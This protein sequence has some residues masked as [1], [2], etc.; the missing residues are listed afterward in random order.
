M[1]NLKYILLIVSTFL[2]SCEDFLEKKPLDSP[3]T[4]SFLNN[5]QEM[6]ASLNS[7]YRSIHWDRGLTPIQQF[8]D[9]WS[10]IG[11]FRDPGIA[12]GDFDTNNADVQKIWTNAYITIQRANTLINGMKVG[13]ENVTPDQYERI[14][15]E[16]RVIRAWAYHFLAFMFGN[17]PL[18][19]EPLLP[20]KY[21]M[22]ATSKDKVI[23][24][25]IKELDESSKKLAWKPTTRGHV[26]KGVALGLLSR[27]ALY[28]KN[29]ELASTAAFEV[30]NSKEF[31]LNPRFQ[32][33]FTR[34]GQSVNKN[35]EIM[36]EFYRSDNSYR[37]VRNYVPLGQ[38][39]RNLGGQSGKFPTQRLVDMFE[40]VDGKRIDESPLYDPENPSKNR[41][42]RLR[43]TVAMHGDTITHYGA[44]NLPRTCIFNI[45]DN[46]TQFYNYTTNKWYTAT[47]N[48]FS[49]PYGPVSSGVG[50]LTAKYTY[51][52]EQINEARVSWIYL[53]YA[54]ILL[55]YAEA[56]IELNRL[57]EQT[58]QVINQVRL[59]SSMPAVDPLIQHSQLEMKQLIRR[60]RTVE[61][62]M[63]GFRW[64]DIRRWE[65][66]EH[67]FPGLIVGASKNKNAVAIPNFKTNEITDL[68]NIPDYSQ[69]INNRITRDTRYYD[70]KHYLL[71]IPQR[72]IDLNPNLNQNTGW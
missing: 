7:L 64:F 47:N 18:V 3:T 12:T 37:S 22:D 26:G 56:N 60:E 55:T 32:D 33:L 39:S 15:A 41:D 54:E 49:N 14:E 13:K 68:N 63:E 28:N 70:K 69:S 25:I 44:N 6:E 31:S 45:Y 52:D 16:A 71:P 57:N 40:C 9:L 5:Q 27:V 10:D 4:A 23:D 66:L 34:S 50:Y 2:F 48:D 29:Y 61:L 38:G 46:T 51:T 42:T 30:I 43:W 72:E 24:F 11:Q 67:V 1:K 19:V 35:G 53:R 8:F 62:A 21:K 58:I 36:F 17:V 65:I 59:R 20:S